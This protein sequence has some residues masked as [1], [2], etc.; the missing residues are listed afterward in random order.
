MA[1][2]GKSRGGKS[3]SNLLGGLSPLVLLAGLSSLVLLA[4]CQNPLALPR[5]EAAPIQ[6]DRLEYTLRPSDSGL[7]GVETR[8]RYE[9]TNRTDG[10]LFIVN[11][12]GATSIV[13]EREIAG[14][15]EVVWANI[16]PACL[17]PAIEL[18]PGQTIERELLVFGGDPGCNCVPKFE[19]E[20]R[21]GVYRMVLTDVTSSFDPGSHPFGPLL[22]AEQRRS[23]RFRIVD[24]S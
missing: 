11:C 4:A 1:A 8:I 15:W 23:N 6:T 14:Q 2:I 22:P 10:P 9:Y 19:V 17:S 20:D 5:D 24:G 13:L 12:R 7:D 3:R 16:I 21:E 18:G